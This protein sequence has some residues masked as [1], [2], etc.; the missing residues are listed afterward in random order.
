MGFCDIRGRNVNDVAGDDCGD[1]DNDNDDK[2]DKE[3][4]EEEDLEE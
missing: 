3:W 1:D 4:K 2:E